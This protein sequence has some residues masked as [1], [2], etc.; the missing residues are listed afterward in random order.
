[1]TLRVVTS[2]GAA[3]SAVISSELNRAA[4][5]CRPAPSFGSGAAV[6]PGLAT[7]PQPAAA[8]SKAAVT[9]ASLIDSEHFIAVPPE[10]LTAGGPARFRGVASDQSTPR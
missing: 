9:A 7:L 1:M 5:R 10:R 6:V 4:S 2:V 8:S 3:P